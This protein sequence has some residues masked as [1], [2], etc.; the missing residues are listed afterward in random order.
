MAISLNW[1]ND[2]NNRRMSE[3][4]AGQI[5]YSNG[6]SGLVW[7]SGLGLV[8]TTLA[9]QSGAV[10]LDRSLG[11]VFRVLLTGNATSLA[12]TNH[13]GDGSHLEIHFIQDATGSRTLA[14]INAAF[15]LAGGALTLST[16][17]NKIDVLTFRGIGAT[18]IE[19]ARALNIS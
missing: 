6:T 9:A 16:A 8:P 4:T 19:T 11:P 2:R 17:A 14:G 3:G 5:P 12:V 10:T 18:W 15:K 13:P 1:W 7:S